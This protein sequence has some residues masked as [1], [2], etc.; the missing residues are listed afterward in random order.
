M[1]VK[2]IT[3]TE[4]AY[5]TLKRMKVEDESFSEAIIRIGSEKKSISD[6]LGLLKDSDES[7]EKMQLRAAETRKRISE[8][9]RKRHAS[10]RHV[11][12]N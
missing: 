2:T 11:G 1:T 9:M 3:V 8:S 10:F 6:F 5:E 7:A 12:D 4:V